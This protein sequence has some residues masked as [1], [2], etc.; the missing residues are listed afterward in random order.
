MTPAQNP[1]RGS[2]GDET[3]RMLSAELQA[4]KSR[5]RI[6]REESV[7]ANEELRAANDELRSINEELRTVNNELKLKFEGVLRAHGD[8]QNL[9]AATD[10]GTL[11][12]DRSLRIKRFTSRVVD[13]FSF[14]DS[15]QGRPITDFTHQLEY[16][17]LA[18]DARGV[19]EHLAP[20][21][22]EIRTH[23]QRWYLMRMRPY[24]AVDDKI[25]GVF[26]TFVDIT[27]RRDF[28][29]AL[30]NSEEQ[31]RQKQQL[32]D[33]SR[34]PI[35]VWDFDNGIVEWNRGSEQLYGYTRDEALGRRKDQLLRTSVPGSSFVELRHKLLENGTWS[36]ELVHRTKD[37]RELM[38]ES[39]I[40]LRP[41]AGRRLVL[42]TTRD[43]TDRKEWERQ[44][45]LLLG[46]LT[47]RVKNT[48]AIVQSIAHQTLN[49]S[50]TREDF[51][52]SLDGR[53][54]ALAGA[55]TLLV[56][57]NWRGAELGALARHQLEPLMSGDLARLKIEGD[58]IMLPAELATPF[59]LVLHELAANATK[60]GA[61]SN[62]KGTVSL[63]W[64][65]NSTD[66]SR[67][68]AVT[69]QERDAPPMA[70]PHTPG[71]GTS[72]IERAI[73]NAKACHQFLP[74]GIVWIIELP[75][76]HGGR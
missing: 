62:A 41:M 40:E 4:A 16:D 71:F 52:R 11:F 18:E 7:A 50:R 63:S 15:D 5:L 31:L 24:R 58:P 26:I 35:F 1:Q 19:L 72:L 28:E 2:A 39:R 65:V 25:D 49:T 46:E 53:L 45:K 23:T 9:M 6:M 60:Y 36:G 21:E 17:S 47:H 34:E 70:K 30:R 54:S 10:F 55:H 75:L 61:L 73:P 14:T 29:E 64:K 27:E 57:S 66:D 13:L 48:L 38:V 43:I 22:R 56:D 42:E 33:L 76:P 74:G 69:W 12:L 51:V 68:L 44:Q 3:A 59:G 20:I 32:I 67:L 8:L 37:G